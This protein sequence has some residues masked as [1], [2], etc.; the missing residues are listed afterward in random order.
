MDEAVPDPLQGGDV[1]GHIRRIAGCGV[2][3]H[4][5]GPQVEQ[6]QIDL[7]DRPVPQLEIQRGPCHTDG[8]LAG[9]GGL[10]SVDRR[11]FNLSSNYTLS[12]NTAL[13]DNERP[14]ASLSTESYANMMNDYG[15]SQLDMRHVFTTTG[16]VYLPGG[17]ELMTSQRFTSG[18]PFDAR[19]GSDLNRDGNNN[20]R[21]L[22]DGSVIKR[23]SY[24]NSAFYNVDLR[25][26]RHFTL[27][28]ER[29]NIVFSAD[30]FNVFNTGNVR[31]AGPGISYGNAGT[32]VQNGQLVQLGPQNPAA[33]MQ[34][35]DSQGGYIRS[36]SPGDP[37]QM[38]LRLRFEF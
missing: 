28:N 25:V 34:L 15:W 29:G 4:P 16:L 30:F 13:S 10:L 14:V 27:P 2:Q 22:L 9:F 35:T 38:Q 19:T 5:S 6:S 1:S 11:H 17:I 36:N 18:R 20:D 24:R 23:N 37:F 31:L 8:R 7:G 32:V 12:Y 21:P 3:A 26:E 33:F